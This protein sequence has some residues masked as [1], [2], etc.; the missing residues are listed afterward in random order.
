MEQIGNESRKDAHSQTYSGRVKNFRNIKNQEKIIKRWT[1]SVIKGL[2][3][4]VGRS[5]YSFLLEPLNGNQ[6]QRVVLYGDAAGSLI[7]EGKTI[8]VIGRQNK[9]GIIIGERIYEP[10]M[11]QHIQAEHILSSNLIRFA[12]VLILF[13]VAYTI[14]LFTKIKS[15][16]ISI[17]LSTPTNILRLAAIF[18]FAAICLKGQ[19]RIIHIIGWILMGLGIYM[20]YPPH[21]SRCRL[22][23]YTEMDAT[24]KTQKTVT[25]GKYES[26][27]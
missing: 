16:G 17:S 19:G 8:F 24:V 27:Y 1:N 21:R 11:D 5:R 10:D 25:G 3:F 12:T 14:F 6:V 9:D 15:T 18:V 13:A 22:I 2:P 23:F 26:N 20:V 4:S 7:T